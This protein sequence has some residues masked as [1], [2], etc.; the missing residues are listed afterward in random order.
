MTNPSKASVKAASSR[1]S[2]LSPPA[3]AGALT[4]S[5]LCWLSFSAMICAC[6]CLWQGLRTEASLVQGRHAV[7]GEALRT[8]GYL[9]TRKTLVLIHGCTLEPLGKIK[10]FW[11]LGHT[12][13]HS[14]L[15]GL[16]RGLDTGVFN[17]SQVILT[18]CNICEPLTSSTQHRAWHHVGANTCLLLSGWGVVGDRE[19]PIKRGTC[20]HQKPLPT[21]A[22]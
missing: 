21:V 3:P 2:S 13:R 9:I 10:K 5:P 11:C 16:E 6:L 7:R 4:G 19:G 8:R 1:K 20:P 15:T 12:P 22:L 17:S 14:D 18:C